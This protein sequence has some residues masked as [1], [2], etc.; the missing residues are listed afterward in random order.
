MPPPHPVDLPLE[1]VERAI[2]PPG[3][4]QQDL[5]IIQEIGKRMG[6]PWNYD[7]PADVFTEMTQV[8]PSLVGT[9]RRSSRR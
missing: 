2:K 3:D 9:A 1:L 6:L 8:M 5:W 7:G 4:A